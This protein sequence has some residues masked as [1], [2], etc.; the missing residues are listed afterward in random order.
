MLHIATLG[1]SCVTCGDGSAVSLDALQ[2]RRMALL[3]YLGAARPHGPQRRDVV[4]AM[5]WPEL[6]AARA[7]AALR[8]AL[9]AI[10]K[11]LG[12]DAVVSHGLETLELSRDIFTCDV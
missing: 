11:S 1:A 3:A 4:V 9:H 10:R 6:D 8:Q 2:P 7:R 12:A 5:L